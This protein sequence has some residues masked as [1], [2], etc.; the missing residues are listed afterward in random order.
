[1]RI[2][3]KSFNVMIFV[4]ESIDNGNIKS[5]NQY[6]LIGSSRP[7]SL[8][9]NHKFGELYLS[10]IGDPMLQL[11]KWKKKWSHQLTTWHRERM[12]KLGRLDK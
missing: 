3:T 9:S 10:P 2:R 6:E 8:P 7:F 1:M 12:I 5:Q 11:L 4:G